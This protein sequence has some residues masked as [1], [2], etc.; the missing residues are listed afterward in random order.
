M[1]LGTYPFMPF[2][3]LPL[4]DL[5]RLC[6]PAVQLQPHQI[7]SVIRPLML[8]PSIR[9]DQ[10][11]PPYLYSPNSASLEDGTGGKPSLPTE[12]AGCWVGVAP[13]RSPHPTTFDNLSPTF[14]RPCRRLHLGDSLVG[15]VDE[16]D[17][18][19][20]AVVEMTLHEQLVEPKGR[21]K[22]S[23]ATMQATAPSRWGTQNI[24]YTFVQHLI[25]RR[26]PPRRRLFLGQTFFCHHAC[27]TLFPTLAQL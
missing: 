21:D 4:L 26:E 20:I 13:W 12:D 9:L 19:L 7:F 25:M 3:P 15:I 27:R 1:T 8:L 14:F 24:L 10:Y 16:V 6:S 2:L 23:V 22:L 11:Q 17:A 18:R 5:Q